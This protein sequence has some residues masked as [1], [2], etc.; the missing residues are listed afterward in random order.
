[1]P[2]PDG[3]QI[4]SFVAEPIPQGDNVKVWLPPGFMKL[5]EDKRR[6]LVR[7]GLFYD[8]VHIVNTQQTGSNQPKRFTLWEIHPI[9]AVL[10][11]TLSDNS[12]D[13]ATL[14]QWTALK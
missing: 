1:V 5:K 4:Q 14:S 2:K 12:C 10:V 13:P 7:G 11:C 8:S 6:I 3:I 9:T